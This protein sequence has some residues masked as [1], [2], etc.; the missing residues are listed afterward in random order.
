MRIV[1]QRCKQAKVSVDNRVIGSIEKGLTLL[2]GITHEDTEKEAGYLAEKIAGLRIFEDAEGKMNLS[3]QD[4]GG[5]ILSVS[6][7]TLYGDCRKGKRPSFISAARPETAEPLYDR[8]N[9]MLREKGLTVETGEFGADMDVEFTNWGPVTLI[10][11]HPF[12]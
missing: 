3:V 4:I 5:A 12:N 2:V 10:L 6:Q 11:E 7:F 9:E 8:F 1:V